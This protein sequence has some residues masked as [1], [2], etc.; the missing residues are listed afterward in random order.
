MIALYTKAIGATLLLA[1]SA[2]G[3]G[4]WIPRLLPET[5]SRLDRAALA[6]VG[7]LGILGTLLFLV[8]QF[9]FS[10]TVILAVLASTA[11]FGISPLTSWIRLLWGEIREMRPY[12]IPA[13]VIAVVLLVSAIAGLAQ[14]A[15]GW[16]TD[17]V[18]YHLYG[19]KIWLR[20]ALVRP[21]PDNC[22]TA[23]PQT[24]E[25][26]FA[27]LM[28]I[29]GARAPG[30]SS[31]LT[32]VG[33]LLVVAA[34]AARCSP[35]KEAAWW[36]AAIAITM[37]AVY[38]G[39]HSGFIDVFYASLVVAA[40]RVALDACA[41]PHYC[42]MGL[43][44]GLA[45]GTK[46]TGLLAFLAILAAAL[47]ARWDEIH[48]G[49]TSSL[50]KGVGVAVGVACCAAAPFYL[51]N[52]I[53][54]GSPIYP[55]PLLLL[56]FFHPKYVTVE[57]LTQMQ[58]FLW[59]RGAG[60]GRGLLAYF[61]LPYNLTYHTSNFHGAGGIGLA[62]LAFLPIAVFLALRDRALRA[63]LIF[64][65]ITTTLW[66]VQQESRYL[67]PAYAVLAVLAV[68][69]W[70]WLK[71]ASSGKAARLLAAAVVALSLCYGGFMILSARRSEM[72]ATLS[73]GYAEKL[74]QEQTPYFESFQYLNASKSVR[75]VL[76]LDR[77]VMPYNLNC[78]YVK[79]IGTWG[80][81]VFP[82][83]RDSADALHQLKN[84]GISHVMDVHSS[85]ALFQVP[86]HTPGLKLVLDLPDQRVYLVTE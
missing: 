6:L 61:L 49:R 36:G 82:E 13:A 57:M 62:P 18:A 56:R 7:G 10:R 46:Y 68:A 79:P 73:Q 31:V 37:P 54:L 33:F 20:D 55:P 76:V 48:A 32:T 59:Q 28:S 71:R 78:D 19:P 44:S 60:L 8:G 52:W 11:V 42:V 80:E 70:Q 81:R 84:L 65:W 43:F 53:V 75:K 2:C 72:H 38:A 64:A 21:V 39:S 24:T 27:A 9:M 14:I 4:R 50:A 51:R 85:V 3:A 41:L 74:R 67:I 5:C 35:G 1:F 15:G 30:F 12:R 83:I 66:F 22:L 69:G 23:F 58:S 40:L 77:S 16:E 25:I 45:M 63:L 17:A 26:L 29:G 86:D 47:V 34:L